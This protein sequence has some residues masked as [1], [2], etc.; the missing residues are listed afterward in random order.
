MEEVV[1][2]YLPIIQSTNK[3]LWLDYAETLEVCVKYLKNNSNV[4]VNDKV[5][6]TYVVKQLFLIGY[7]FNA[8]T[9]ETII[10]DFL[11]YNDKEYNNYMGK[12]ALITDQFHADLSFYNFFVLEQPIV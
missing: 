1:R 11:E 5:A 2:K 3:S 12:F 8:R 4:E 10:D 7:N 9:I 6:A